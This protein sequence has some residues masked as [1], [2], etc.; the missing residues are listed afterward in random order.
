MTEGTGTCGLREFHETAI[1][2]IINEKNYRKMKKTRILSYN[3]GIVTLS[4]LP[5]GM[6][7]VCGMERL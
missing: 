5:S 2:T 4:N 7:L 3:C 1:K 6:Y